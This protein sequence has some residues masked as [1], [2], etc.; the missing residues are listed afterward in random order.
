ME[1]RIK[2][3]AFTGLNCWTSS[4]VVIST[5]FWACATF[6]L[7]DPSGGPAQTSAVEKRTAASRAG[8]LTID[9][10]VTILAPADAPEPLQRAAEDLARDFEK[11]LGKKPRIINREQDA[12]STT[13]FIAEQSKLPKTI[14]RA[15]T[16]AGG[17]EAFSISL[18]KAKWNKARP[19]QVILL[20]GSD[21]RGTIYAV[22][23]F[24]EKYLGI[25]PLY[26][27]TDHEPVRR[28]AIEIP[29]SLEEK[30][31]SPVF[32]YRGFF[33]NDEDL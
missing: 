25:D 24:A 33:I 12:G 18:S 5:V 23:E 17:P 13:I 22:Y 11:V 14:S 30:F 31:P 29:S 27:W 9:P 4:I 19:T 21:M 8:V 6:A 20:T 15:T 7:S 16:G 10:S 28:T 1:H 32:K 26:Y 2:R 3:L